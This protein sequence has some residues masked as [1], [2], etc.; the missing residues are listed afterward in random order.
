MVID[1]EILEAH[2][3]FVTGDNAWQQRARLT[4]ALWRE[5]QG[6][7]AGLHRDVPLGSRLTPGDG[8]PPTLAN[9][10]SDPAKR[11]V[12]AAVAKKN[13][14]LLSQPRLWVDLLSSQPLCFNLFGPL[15]EDLDLATATLRLLWPH[16][17]Q[18]TEIKF[19]WSPGRGDERYTG[20]HSAFDVFVAYQNGTSR[21]F[22]GIEVKYHENLRG[23]AATDPKQRYPKIAAKHR[24]FRDGAL[25]DLQRLPLQQLWLDHLLALQ[26]LA[27][28]DDGW[29]EGTFVFLSPTGNVAC[30]TAARR[31]SH[32]LT[33]STTFDA[34]TLDEL[35]QAIRLVADD[36]WADAVYERY[37]DPRPV[38]RALH[39]DPA[40]HLR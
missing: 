37:L 26:L 36:P 23:T 24:I 17:G 6:L 5:R 15:A 9:Y 28:P 11:Q 29:D 13:G 19:E 39:R 14:A 22:L 27:S 25:P 1:R 38:S 2:H 12:E 31:Y 32:A 21:G 8:E 30:T 33:D 34:R 40:R 3:A 20:N 7:A 16:I 18:V 35:V 4:Q 10:I